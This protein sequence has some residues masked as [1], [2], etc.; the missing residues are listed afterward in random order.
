[1][2]EDLYK[3]SEEIEEIKFRDLKIINDNIFIKKNKLK[4]ILIFYTPWCM[5][6]NASVNF[7]NDM[8]N[9]FK[10]KIQIYAYN[11]YDYRNKNEEIGSYLSL[12]QYPSYYYFNE[13]GKINYLNINDKEKIKDW[14]FINFS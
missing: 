9:I 4:G 2:D 10:Y 11:T 7:W 13:D 1:M 14:L 3:D 12:K 5:T 8:A 6:C